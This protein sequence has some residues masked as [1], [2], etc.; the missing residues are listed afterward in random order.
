MIRQQLILTALALTAA[1][2]TTN[3]LE[4]S[5]LS[6]LGDTDRTWIGE[7]FFANRLQDW[8]V[9]GGRL[10]C[11]NG[12]KK[13]PLRTAQLLT[14]SLSSELGGFNAS[15]T[16]G[17]VKEGVLEAEAFHGFLLGG[18]GDHVDYRLSAMIHSKP[19]EDG[20]LL[21]VLGADGQVKLH[22][23]S[24]VYSGGSWSVSG[25]LAADA[26][27][28]LQESSRSGD[29]YG[30][31]GPVPAQLNMRAVPAAESYTLELSA[32][33]IE[34]GALLSQALYEGLPAHQLDGCL[35][36]VSHLGTKES[37]AG[38]WFKSWTLEGAKLERHP[39]RAWGP[40]LSCQHTLSEGTLKLTAQAVPL[41]EDEGQEALLEIKRGRTWREVARAKL[42]PLS[43]TYPFK[44]SGWDGSRDTP[45]RVKSE[46]RGS[47]GVIEER[48]YE[49]VIRAIPEDLVI[50]A[51][52]GHKCFTGGKIRWNS[53]G[54]W[55]PHSELVEAVKHH[56][57]DMLFF[58]GDQLYEG[59][60]V[61]A[62]MPHNGDSIEDYL[63][64]WYR[65]CWVFG[66]LTRDLPA[67]TIPDDHDVYHG[68]IWGA[69]GRKAV[70]RDGMT[71]QDTGGYK[72]DG[73]LVNAIHRTQVSHLPDPHDPTPIEQD[74]SVYYTNLEY[75]G[76]SFAV[77][78]D[79]MWKESPTIAE[80]DGDCKNGFFKAEGFDAS[81][82]TTD[83]PLLGQRQLDFLEDW[84]SNWSEDARFK[85]VLSQTIFANVA[86]LPPPAK[87]DAVTP[88]LKVVAQGE[89][90]PD[91][92]PVSDGDSN[93]WPSKGRDRALR[94][95]RKAFALHIA[96]DQHLG[97]TIR[98]GV[99]DWGDA[100]YAFCVPSVANTWP[101]RWY[102][103]EPGANQA[104]GAA[105]NT[106][107]YLDGFGNK[108]TVFAASN[109]V[110]TGVQP[111]A[112][113]DRAPGYGIVHFNDDSREM[114]LANWPRWVDPSAA[115]AEPYEGWPITVSLLDQYEREPV[116]WLPTIRVDDAEEPLIQVIDETSA[117]VVYT[118][119]VTARSTGGA[120]RP[121]TFSL[122]PHTLRVYLDGGAIFTETKG[123]V[124]TK[125]NTG[126]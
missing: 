93:G 53:D 101:R 56:E 119:R 111:S 35:G 57:P 7:D 13:N 105:R 78:A 26:I 11:S 27:P 12:A 68:N 14:T 117:E 73:R 106:G 91:D 103:S 41:G 109:P 19:G 9:R 108:M 50:A 29:G 118:V 72:L 20:G 34:S 77:L 104:P 87:T 17:A 96:G 92:I 58:S 64:K 67:V 31:N 88:R 113:Y 55:F 95:I 24:G 76:V 70:A 42:T 33:S 10:E 60:L 107:D 16:T 18:G 94:K 85:A 46:A 6:Q 47:D 43:Y 15:V 25:P 69:G 122:K 123:L 44:V 124:P 75:G 97:S 36:L 21:A 32:R 98:Y 115:D 65:W 80:P 89:Y 63:Y 1:C 110:H 23:N 66:D 22:D 74:I 90:P 48:V 49:G 100:G 4:V 102:P 54:I 81:S 126:E 71:S 62:N 120:F 40:V 82:S 52:T 45:Y 39:E 51:F 38:F 116:G 112:L 84:A 59:D 30:E 125:A 114:T 61:G 86:T 121:R 28:R 83:A 5:P 37:R 79:R 99:D 3:R 2:Q 8:R